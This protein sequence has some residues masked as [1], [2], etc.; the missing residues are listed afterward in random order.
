MTIEALPTHERTLP[1]M[2]RPG[3]TNSLGISIFNSNTKYPAISGIEARTRGGNVVYGYRLHRFDS[4]SLIYGAENADLHA[5]PVADGGFEVALTLPL[6][7][8]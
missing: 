5:G 1:A 4:L 6:E 2:L 8:A 3:S 7:L